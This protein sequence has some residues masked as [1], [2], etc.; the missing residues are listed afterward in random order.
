MFV[1]KGPTLQPPGTFIPLDLHH[2]LKQ[3]LVDFES[4]EY[5]GFELDDPEMRNQSG[6]ATYIYATVI[7]KLPVRSLVSL[8][9]LL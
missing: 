7:E 2:L 8:V 5:V 4:E 6:S 3:D 1:A 9:L